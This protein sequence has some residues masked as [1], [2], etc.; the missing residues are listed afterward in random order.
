MGTTT[1]SDDG[2]VLMSCDSA[3]PLLL[4]G[5]IIA[6][7]AESE[8]YIAAELLQQRHALQ[9]QVVAPVKGGDEPAARQDAPG[10]RQQLKALPLDHREDAAE[11]SQM[12]T[13]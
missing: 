4:V 5:K 8:N 11:K 1:P 9:Q 3:V 12:P 6:S 13:A 10:H 7:A 2:A